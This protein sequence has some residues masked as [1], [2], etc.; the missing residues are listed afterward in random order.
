MEQQ[1]Y[2]GEKEND[3]LSSW[4][5]VGIEQI[6]DLFYSRQG[7]FLSFHSFYNKFNVNCNFLQYYSLLSSIPQSWKKIL[8]SSSEGTAAPS[9]LISSLSCKTYTTRRAPSTHFCKKNFWHVASKGW[10]LIK[11]IFCLVTKEIKLIMFQYTITHQILPTNNLLYKM[12]KAASPFCPFCPSECH[13]IWHL[14]VHCSQAT[15]FWSKFRE[16]YLSLG[17][18]NL[19]LS[20]LDIM[21]EIVRCQSN[22]LA[23]NHLIILGKYFLYVNSLNTTRCQI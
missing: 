6:S 23:F 18:T 7:C 22:C 3:I 15:S 12:K 8:N 17:D 1:I 19:S 21:F 9:I 20:E 14:F 5:Q 2:N 16:W 11:F 4:Y 10:T 13:T